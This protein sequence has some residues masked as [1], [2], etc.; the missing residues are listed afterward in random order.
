MTW[1]A[2]A[3]CFSSN[4]AVPIELVKLLRTKTGAPIVDCKNALMASALDLDG[5]H[6]H[7]R[8][9]GLANAHKAA[10]R[11]TTQGVIALAQ[12]NT[13][14]VL[15]ELQTETDFVA[16]NGLF[17]SLADTLSRIALEECEKTDSWV[18]PDVNKVQERAKDQFS[19]TLL[20][21]RENI[22]LKSITGLYRRSGQTLSTYVHN[23]AALNSSLGQIG[24][25]V[26]ADNVENIADGRNIMQNIAM[27]IAVA[28]PSYANLS[29]VPEQLIA[30]ER[31]ILADQLKHLGK[32]QKVLDGIIQG[33]LDKW[34][35]EQVLIEQAY[36]LGDGKQKVISLLNG[37]KIGGFS[38]KRIGE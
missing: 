14:A 4:S 18:D 22:V 17:L 24:V 11:Q 28:N 34:K 32:P 29:D 7:L 37:I 19:D 9:M 38:R 23:K 10:G 20:A 33:K 6:R 13:G 36:A 2:I 8:T 12:N 16:K 35:A 25:M 15:V 5:A 1:R 27:H 21:V 26:T 3:R 30:A 31:A